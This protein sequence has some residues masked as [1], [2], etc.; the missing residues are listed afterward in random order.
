M[1]VTG[2]LIE[3]HLQSHNG[4]YLKP[5][6]LNRCGRHSCGSINSYARRLGYRPKF[7]NRCGVKLSF[8][9]SS[10]NYSFELTFGTNQKGC[11]SNFSTN[12]RFS[13]ATWVPLISRIRS[14][15]R[16]TTNES[17]GNRTCIRYFAQTSRRLCF[18]LTNS[19]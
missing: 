10:K 19:R 17:I 6:L 3:P 2:Y 16:G 8:S 1:V 11:N 7:I 14:R 5:H 18:A 4:N 12:I 9:N 13:Y 15:I